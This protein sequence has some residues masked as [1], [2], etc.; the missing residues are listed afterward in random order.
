[1]F[2]LDRKLASSTCVAERPVGKIK[3]PN[4]I[5][6]RPTRSRNSFH[7]F[8]RPTLPS[9]PKN[10]AITTPPAAPL[11][12]PSSPYPSI[13]NPPSR[14]IRSRKPQAGRSITH[15]E[16][17]PHVPAADRIF[18]WRTPFGSRHYTAV[19]RRL[20]APLVQSALMAVRGALAPNTKS[21][22]GA[23]PLR[24]TQF[25][26]KWNISEEARMPADYALLCA[27]IGEY[28][29]RQS[30]NT[31]RSWLAGLRSWHVINHAPWYGD[32][33]WVHLARTSAN[34]EGTK[35]KLPLRAPV[36][37]EHLSCLRRSL[38]LSTPFHAAV[39]AVALVTF[40]GCRRLGE[41]TLATAAA[42]DPKFHVL[43]ST[44]CVS[45]FLL[46]ISFSLSLSIVFRVL[47]DGTSSATFDIPWTKTTKEL[48][49]TII[50]T[51]RRD[52]DPLCPVAALKNHLTI[53][54]SIPA[55]S[56]LF[57]YKTSSGEPKNLLK[58]EFLNFVTGIWSSAM[59]AHVLGHSFRIG[60]AVELLLAGVPPE[61]VAATGGW[62]SLAFLL[63]WRRMDEILPMST[64]KAY[65]QAHLLR[66]AE[67]FEEF[68]IAH[69]IPS[70]LLDKCTSP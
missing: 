23:G 17:R 55:S 7:P 11:L 62:T 37:I 52:G 63:Y 44:K 19:A 9:L 6:P 56:A 22:Y 42:F 57:A 25:C 70:T 1:M 12:P 46:H 20:P 2:S 43:R 4:S 14:I 50:L 47:R 31:I 13:S 24:F 27:F 34:K 21:T 35:H 67:I 33:D 38:D 8:S 26:D 49:A 32:D 15:N 36:S 48:G 3:S 41:T 54:S 59:L 18:A 45:S 60:G 39:W 10:H 68:R 61:I 51:A 53:N 58:N 28:K 65:N 66:L 64:S 5:S 29:G 30:G 16:F 40:F 69:K